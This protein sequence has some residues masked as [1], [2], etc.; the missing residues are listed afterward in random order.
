MERFATICCPINIFVEFSVESYCL[1]LCK[2]HER[3]Q[4]TDSVL[5]SKVCFMAIKSYCDNLGRPK[6]CFRN[7]PISEALS[8]DS[9]EGPNCWIF[10]HYDWHKWNLQSL[11]VSCC[12]CE[13]M[14]LWI[15]IYKSKKTITTVEYFVV[16]FNARM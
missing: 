5:D 8:L 12:N 6:N 9:L 11:T 13:V 10:L 16:L 1:S 2:Y 15:T 14:A 7:C 4:R 3:S